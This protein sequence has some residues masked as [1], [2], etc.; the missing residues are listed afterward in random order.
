M[1]HVPGVKHQAPDAMS[2]YPTGDHNPD[3]MYLVD[4]VSTITQNN[5]QNIPDLHRNFLS[6]IRRTEEHEDYME[7][8]V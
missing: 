7:T 3:R 1:V 4:D 8:S 2:H 6:G 5:L